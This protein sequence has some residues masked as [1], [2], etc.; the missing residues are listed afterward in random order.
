ML[1][2]V[3]LREILFDMKT[4]RTQVASPVLTVMKL[5][6]QAPGGWG[7]GVVGITVNR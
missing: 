4:G 3:T 6:E 2:G 1:N 7:G 5:V